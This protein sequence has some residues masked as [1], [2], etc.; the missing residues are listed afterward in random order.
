MKWYVWIMAMLTLT[1]MAQADFYG[2]PWATNENMGWIE[3]NE[4][5]YP[6]KQCFSG[7]Q[8]RCEIAGISE[9]AIVET[10][11]WPFGFT[12]L[13]VTNGGEIYTNIYETYSN[14]IT[15]NAISPVS[16]DGGS[17]TG[18]PYVTRYFMHQLQSKTEEL[19]PLFVST[20][21]YS[22]GSYSN[23][24]WTMATNFVYPT[25]F[26]FES[27]AGLFD[28]QGIGYVVTRET[29][30]FGYV[31]GG[32]A[33]WTRQPTT[34]TRLVLAEARSGQPAAIDAVG[35]GVPEAT[36]EYF[37]HPPSAY[38][39]NASGSVIQASGS[40]Y[41]LSAGFDSWTNSEGYVST[42]WYDIWGVWESN[43]YTESSGTYGDWILHDIGEFPTNYY[44]TNYLPCL[45]Y[46][47]GGT[48]AINL[49]VTLSGHAWIYTNQTT[50]STTETVS[51]SSETTACAVAWQDIT[52][53]TVDADAPDTGDVI[54]VMYTNEIVLYGNWPWTLHPDDLD[55]LAAALSALRWTGSARVA[56][57][58]AN[59]YKTGAGSDPSASTAYDE[60]GSNYTAYT[61]ANW[62]GA[63]QVVAAKEVDQAPYEWYGSRI[64]PQG[65]ATN[66]WTKD[67]IA[68]NIQHSAEY[69]ISFFDR[70]NTNGAVVSS[71]GYNANYDFD[72]L[73]GGGV[74]AWEGPQD[75]SLEDPGPLYRMQTLAEAAVTQ[76][77]ANTPTNYTGNPFSQIWP[78]AG[79]ASA[80]WTNTVTNAYTIMHGG[81]AW[82]L[83]WDGGNGLQYK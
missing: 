44:A 30:L 39:V 40:G 58:G 68:T 19:M 61:P 41:Q 2:H 80:T 78:S 11:S 31:T 66:L 15:T 62:P 42:N 23:Y 16:Y 49:N 47:R 25:N 53:I 29:N 37:W 28:R 79:A 33:Y 57:Q 63:Y 18:Y 21:P 32:E 26:L 17:R 3:L 55:E 69:Y 59:W 82:L 34:T 24:L 73:V 75:Q 22:G 52:N 6:I 81:D 35:F 71:V 77:V 43:A 56:P 48:N 83:K 45:V 13:V 4:E 46:V 76:R 54:V 8:E 74:L 27:K 72:N 9:L 50:Y 7:I 14:V 38:Y 12:N 36:A 64:Q 60:Q 51:V 70:R 10:W 67:D 1:K 5:F 65:L 20:N